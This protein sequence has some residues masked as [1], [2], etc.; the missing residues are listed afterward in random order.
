MK[1][2]LVLGNH[3]DRKAYI[4]AGEYNWDRCGGPGIS[5]SIVWASVDVRRCKIHS[6]VACSEIWTDDVFSRPVFRQEWEKPQVGDKFT[7]SYGGKEYSLKLFD[8]DV[9]AELYKGRV[10]NPL[11]PRERFPHLTKKSKFMY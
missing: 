3:T 2:W 8:D 4:L 6:I 7:F 1:L 11:P 10:E 5:D 9:F